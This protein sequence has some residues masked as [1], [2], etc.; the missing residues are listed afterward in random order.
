MK[1]FTCGAAALLMLL[2]PMAGNA[3]SVVAP[4][5]DSLSRLNEIEVV[6]NLKQTERLER[7]PLSYSELPMKALEREGISAI[8]EFSSYAPNFYQPDYGSRITSS[9]YVR[10]FGSRMD[11][12]VVGLNVDGVPLMNKN[13]FD[14]DFLDVRRIELL[15]GPQGTLYG[16]NTSGGVINITTLSPFVWQ[17]LKAAVEYDSKESWLARLSYYGTSGKGNAA[18]IE[19]GGKGFGYSF[20]ASLRHQRGEHINTATGEYADWGNDVG[21]RNRLQW[22][23]GRGWSLD[24]TIMFSYTRQG[25]YPYRH[26]DATSGVLEPLAYN[27]TCGYRRLFVTEG[28]S[29]VKRGEKVQLSLVTGINWLDDKMRLDQDFTTRDYFTLTQKQRELTLSQE[30]VVKNASKSDR[31]QWLA[32]AFLFWKE[33]KISAPVD[34][35]KEGIEDLILS[36]VNSILSRVMPHA[37]LSLTEE[38]FPIE[39]DFRIP[40]WGAALFHES[41]WRFG[42][43]LITAG[44]RLDLERASM[45]YDSRS[46]VHYR[47]TPM[48]PAAKE[49]LTTFAGRESVDFARVL[50]KLAVSYI[51]EHGDI[52]ATVTRGYRAGGFNTNI[53]SDM[54][55]NNM[56]NNMMKDMGLPPAMTDKVPAFTDAENATFKPEE[57]WNFELGAHLQPLKGL[58][59]SLSTFY[60]LCK[61]QQVTVLPS[62]MSTGRMMSN[63]A[64]SHSLGAEMLLSYRRGGLNLS[65]AYGLTRAEFDRYDDGVA[66]YKGKR[67]PYAPSSTL[68]AVAGY[69]WNFSGAGAL[70]ALE[71][72]ANFNGI[73]KIWW[74][75]ANE[76]SQAFYSLLGAHL[77]ADFG[78]F[79]ITAWGKNILDTKYN[80]FYFV[81]L[82]EQFFCPGASARFGIKLDFEL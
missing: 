35:H 13:A 64:K 74:D 77:T 23:R 17:G 57:N 4:E 19:S 3:Q 10:G 11:Q 34:F 22:R 60:I 29:A 24:N 33:Q 18:G 28:F 31:W 25:G 58:E 65:A 38:S 15:R 63:A 12:P 46:L 2:V 73:G 8:K 50:P 1:S 68:S 47:L 49:L 16:R 30:V 51:T 56:M 26:F 53:F 5:S 9:I 21:I 45:T 54:L 72:G 44:I 67:L 14:F 55:Q 71:A 32:G 27:D 37:R 69:R 20:A 66:D 39:S 76:E 70:K 40:T 7:L 59:I 62:G 75:N 52:Y 36:G 6:A 79:R 42:K 78:R 48:M 61:N 81:S 41:N 43:W 80:T 82:S